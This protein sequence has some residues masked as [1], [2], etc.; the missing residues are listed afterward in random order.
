VIVGIGSLWCALVAGGALIGLCRHFGNV[1]LPEAA[2]VI[3][4][5]LMAAILLWRPEGSSRV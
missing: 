1:L 5:V 4:Y 2:V 3:D